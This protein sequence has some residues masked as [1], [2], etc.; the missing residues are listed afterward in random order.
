ME[1]NRVWKEPYVRRQRRWKVLRA[2]GIGASV[3]VAIVDLLFYAALSL[4][5]E[6]NRT[7]GAIENL[8][9]LNNTDPKTAQQ[10]A[11]TVLGNVAASLWQQHK[12]LTVLGNVAA[13]LEH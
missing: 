6:Y 4:L 2:A 5:S 12:A 9:T 11:P 10:K 1:S 3:G 13:Y 8:L 7:D